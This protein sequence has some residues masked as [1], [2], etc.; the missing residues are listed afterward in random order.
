MHTKHSKHWIP[1]GNFKGF[2]L[3]VAISYDR[4]VQDTSDSYERPLLFSQDAV[5]L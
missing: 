1:G 5:L 4:Q 3:F 2:D